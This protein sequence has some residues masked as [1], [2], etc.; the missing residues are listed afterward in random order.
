[1]SNGFMGPEGYGPDPF[2]E[3]LARFFGAGAVRSGGRGS[4][5]PGRRTSPA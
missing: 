5:R 3:F 2:G 1:M 4:P